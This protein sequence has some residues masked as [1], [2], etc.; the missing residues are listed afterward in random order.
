VKSVEVGENS[1]QGKFQVVQLVVDIKTHLLA[2]SVED[3]RSFA[4]R[5][6]PDE[7]ELDFLADEFVNLYLPQLTKVIDDLIDGK[8]LGAIRQGNQVVFGKVETIQADF[9]TWFAELPSFQPFLT[10]DDIIL[11]LWEVG[12]LTETP[13]EL[14]RV[15]V[16][17]TLLERGYTDAGGGRWMRPEK[18]AE[19]DRQVSRRLEVPRNHSKIK[20]QFGDMEELDA[21][22]FI[23]LPERARSFLEELEVESDPEETV[24]TDQPW[25]PPTS[26][27]KMPA[28]SYLNIMQGYFPLTGTLLRAFPPRE[29]AG[30]VDVQLVEGED[31]RFVVNLQERALKSI[32]PQA[33]YRRF[34]SELAIPAGTFLWLEYRGDTRYRIVPRPFGT[35]RPV[36]CKQAWLEEDGSLHVEEME[37]EMRFD[38]DEHLFR[39]E[40][41]FEDMDALFKEAEE[42][43][44]SI[45]DAIYDVFPKLA[46]L[47]PDGLV[48][49]SDIFNAVFFEYRMCSYRTVVHELYDHACFAEAGNGYFRFAPELG[50]NRRRPTRRQIA[51][52]FWKEQ[53]VSEN[54]KT[55]IPEVEPEFWRQIATEIPRQL[56]T[57]DEQKPFEI[58]SVTHET[59]ELIVSTGQ[60]R[61][62]QRGDIEQAWNE[63]SRHGRVDRDQVTRFANFNVA[64]VMAILAQLP[65][66]SHKLRPLRLMFKPVVTEQIEDTEILGDAENVRSEKTRS[67]QLIAPDLLP[68]EPLFTGSQETSE[69][70]W[71]E[72]TTSDSELQSNSLTQE[73]RSSEQD[74]NKNADYEL[75]TAPPSVDLGQAKFEKEQF[76]LGFPNTREELIDFLSQ[77]KGEE[78]P[79]NRYSY[80]V[81]ITSVSRSALRFRYGNYN[82]GIIK[83]D[84]LFAAWQSLKS[85]KLLRRDELEEYSAGFK[86]YLFLILK[87]FPKVSVRGR[88]NI[89]VYEETGAPLSHRHVESESME[90][91]PDQ[92]DTGEDQS[93]S[94]PSVPAIPLLERQGTIETSTKTHP[95]S[96]KTR[97]GA[98]KGDEM[99]NKTLFSNNFMN[100]RLGSL[101]EWKEDPQPV[102]GQMRELWQKA[103]RFGETWNEAQ[104]EEEFI[105]PILKLLGWSYV[106]QAKAKRGG[107]V[108]RPDYALF[109]DEAS[110]DEAQPFQGNDDAFY[111]RALAIAEAKHWGRPLSAKDSSGRATWKAESNPSHQMVSYLV[112]TRTEWGILTNGR[113]WRLY[114][115]EVSSTASEFYEVDL[116]NLF[117]F[118]PEGIQPSPAQVDDF[119]RWWLFFRREAFTREA[120]AKSFVQRVHEG[121]AMYASEISDKLK[122]LVFEDVMPEIAGGFVA[123]R[124]HQLGIRE[125]TP[126]SLYEIYR[127]SLS[128]L[129]KMLFLLYAEARSLLPMENPDYRANSLTMIA[130]WA[131]E[132][133]DAKR[134]LSDA[135]YATPRYDSLLAIFRRID[136]GDPALG[137]PEYNG[138]LFSPKNAANIFLDGHK[139]SD[140]AV[141]LAVDTLVRDAGQPVDYAFISVRNLGAIY[142]GL[143]EN[144]LRVVNAAA[145]KV[146]LINDK[147]ER[148]ATGSYYTPDYIVEYIVQNTLDPILEQRNSDYAR[149]MERVTELRGQLR[150]VGD[151]ATATRLR[152]QLEEAERESREAFLGIK[153]LDPAMG[154]GHFLVNAVDH[155]TDGIIQRMQTW[156]DVHPE[157][158]WEWDPIQQL[159]ERVRTEI[160][161]ELES[162]GLPVDNR[163]NDDTALL[164]RL[165]MKRCIYGVD[166]NEMAVELARVS[167]WLHTF[168][169]GAPLSFL[170]HHLR[171]GNSLIGIS[172][173]GNY[174]TPGTERWNAVTRTLGAMVQ[175]SNMTDSTIGEV[176]KSST[177][178]KESREWIQ[179]TIERLNVELA[180]YFTEWGKNQKMVGQVSQLAYLDDET[181]HSTTSPG[182]FEKYQ[183]AQQLAEEK[184]FFHWDLEFPEVS[185]DLLHHDWAKEPGFD[186]VIGNPPYVKSRMGDDIRIERKIIASLPRYKALKHM[187]DVYVAFLE[188]SLQLI[189]INGIMTF[190]IPD[191]FNNATYSEPLKENYLDNLHVLE[192]SHFPEIEIFSGVGVRNIIISVRKRLEAEKDQTSKRVVHSGLSP[193]S[194]RTVTNWPNNSKELY[195]PKDLGPTDAAR[196]LERSDPLGNLCYV[197][198]GLRL[199]SSEHGERGKFTKNDLL[200]DF[201]DSI[202]TREFVEG[203]FLERYLIKQKRYLEWN[204]DRSPSKLVRPTFPELYEPPKLF[205]GRQTRVVAFDDN[206]VICDNTVMVCFPYIHLKGIEN[207]NINRYLNNLTLPRTELENK[208]KDVNLFYVMAILNSNLGQQML[209]SFRPGSI[210]AYPDDWKNIPIY[211]IKFNSTTEIRVANLAR[212]QE[213]YTMGKLDKLLELVTDYLSDQTDI[214]HDVL[215]YLAEQMIE[216]NKARQEEMKG[217]LTHLSR[218]VGADL[219][220]LTG[221]TTLFNYLGDYQ[222]GEEAAS[223]DDI[224]AVLRKN[225]KKLSVDISARAFQESLAREYQSSL[226]KLLPIKKRLAETDRLIDQ[227]VY[228][229][230]GLTEEEIAIVEGK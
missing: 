98:P 134:N 102:I 84:I 212:V 227:I 133:I 150:K 130:E 35:P 85:R 178:Y 83:I 162:N 54:G 72:I 181:R 211:R 100:T 36:R 67:G 184:R 109:A 114:S 221:K 132:Q 168:T 152:A 213:L 76:E 103:A 52:A 63:L 201:T 66:V 217:F 187:W 156:H 58:T 174:I 191:A 38:G 5:F 37:I 18:L 69:D 104:T 23:V 108:T 146:E 51:R 21:D 129:Y 208:S 142:E 73:E 131:A 112:G 105:K 80:P 189:K 43:D 147:G 27:L 9:A 198:Y 143:L 225:Q 16:E 86:S 199:N 195:I 172:D 173:I 10:I 158:P 205:L 89:L 204:T 140:R 149:G 64:Y 183:Q 123:Y 209:N 203:S 40:L 65:G 55:P 11:K 206:K 30:L 14:A 53:P 194:L 24:V 148:K 13:E 94:S 144:K 3:A 151:S 169:V 48:H 176:A 42:R 91:T 125:E 92:F 101:P 155:L 116:G 170:D 78:I 6:P 175:I 138:G 182:L 137:I 210:D 224:L 136:R 157:S 185:V 39:A 81:I 122:E 33:V 110:K 29:N 71:R 180:A 186:A 119:K 190:I 121:S 2:A 88:Q 202:H 20:A 74:E 135:T 215:V 166:L 220:N 60:P 228:A 164:M 107:Q 113:T 106:V 154:S 7:D 70:A 111:G 126:E 139:L 167:L 31:V 177:L 47:R 226:E 4:F 223:L 160:R 196:Y 1:E 22:D 219:D 90:T 45:F 95:S 159:I 96:S 222:K 127:A 8:K 77:F 197:T 145:G 120:E 26:P 50:V 124:F 87:Q 19:F 128:L 192:V 99:Q 141:A 28:L 171:W 79:F 117:D 200:Q 61:T 68:T 188:T 59:V 218:E 163:L 62:L 153:V 57:L 12:E 15:I 179:P 75:A 161:R 82:H 56:Q 118:L 115:R 216:M 41:R 229:L 32:D 193:D 17:K 97:A 46:A 49:Y 44:F 93:E 230:Y 214:V 34:V 165:V 25:T 207:P